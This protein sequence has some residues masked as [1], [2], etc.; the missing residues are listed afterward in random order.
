MAYSSD[1][2][3]Y[4]KVQNLP[5]NVFDLKHSQWMKE[6]KYY[7][8]QYK[9]ALSK[10]L[11]KTNGKCV[12][13]GAGSCALSLCCSEFEG[14]TSITA[15]DISE[16]R[17]RALVSASS[18]HLGISHKKLKI[19]E[20]DFNLRL[21][22]ENKS[23]GAILFDASLHHSRT[24]WQTLAEA[25]RVLEDDG[26]LVAQRESFLTAFRANRQLNRLLKTPEVSASV[27]ENMYLLSQYKYYLSVSG[28]EVAF[29][30]TSPNRLKRFLSPFNG[31]VFCDGILYAKKQRH[32][33]F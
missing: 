3:F 20:H 27:S 10:D 14:C 12:E 15:V 16:K 31:I 19:L 2:K 4:D 1:K 22:F 13:L 17:M 11:L 9:N 18:T 21:P 26:V 25:N 6:I 7:F 24:I 23:V 5:D 29:M 28:F 32:L 33:E 8:D 30:P